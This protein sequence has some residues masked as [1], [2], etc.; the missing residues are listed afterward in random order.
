MARVRSNVR[1][2]IGVSELKS[3]KMGHNSKYCQSGV[4][5]PVFKIKHYDIC[6]SFTPIQ[7]LLFRIFYEW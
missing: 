5:I 7:R 3:L 1:R 6:Y 4:I 2:K